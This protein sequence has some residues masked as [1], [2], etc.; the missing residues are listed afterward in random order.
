M[1]HRLFMKPT[2]KSFFYF[3]S[4]ALITALIIFGFAFKRSDNTEGTADVRQDGRLQYKWYAPALPGAA[5][6]AGEKVPLDRQEIREQ[7]DREVLYNYYNI[8]STLYIIKLTTRYFP[9]I[10]AH[11]KAN[12]VPDDFKYLC[13]AE[14]SLQNQT[15]RAG[16]VGFWQFMKDTAPRYGLQVDDEVDERYNV[17]RATDAACLY[18]KEAYAKFGSWTAA[19]ASYNCG[20][21][22]YNTQAT[23]QQTENYYDLLLPDE[24]MRYVFRIVALKYYITQAEKLGFIIEPSDEYRPYKTQ[25]VIISATIPDLTQYALDKGI[26]Y[27]K[28]KMFNPWLRGHTLTVLPGKTYEIQLPEG[29]E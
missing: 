26:S 25:P 23:Y 2:F 1:Q 4:G 19:A 13:V 18:F 28:L 17:A 24:T 21:N 10:E 5:S 14:S 29:I 12:G 22:G 16:A 15:S 27:R 20:E 11:L 6:F 8:Y 7:L 9:I 3:S